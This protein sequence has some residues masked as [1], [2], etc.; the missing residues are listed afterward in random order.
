MKLNAA[1]HQREKGKNKLRKKKKILT[2]IAKSQEVQKEITDFTLERG[3]AGNFFYET[4]K[5]AYT[6]RQQ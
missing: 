5:S 3:A 4:G 2:I 1:K 6:T